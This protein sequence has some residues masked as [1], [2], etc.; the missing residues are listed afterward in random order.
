MLFV[1][2]TLERIHWKEDNMKQVVRILKEPNTFYI[3]WIDDANKQILNSVISLDFNPLINH[4]LNSDFKANYYCLLHW[5]AKPKGLRQWGVF[6]STTSGY[7]AS[8]E[9]TFKTT[10]EPKTIQLDETKVKTLPTSVM[11]LPYCKVINYSA[12]ADS[13]STSLP[14]IIGK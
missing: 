6:D 2:I 8:R 3:Y 4:V 9:I 12:I 1:V 5:Q 14:V 7:Y 10:T 11:F 13:G